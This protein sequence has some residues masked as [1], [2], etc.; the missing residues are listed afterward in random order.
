MLVIGYILFAA[1]T[2]YSYYLE[3]NEITEKYANKKVKVS[4]VAFNID[5]N[6]RDVRF[7]IQKNGKG[8]FVKYMGATPDAFGEGVPVVVEGTYKN[9]T[10]FAQTL[11]TKCPSKY[12]SAER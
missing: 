12:E 4:G 9:D 1:A 2:N 8:V 3:A 11:L 7:F 5:K 6:G 10:I